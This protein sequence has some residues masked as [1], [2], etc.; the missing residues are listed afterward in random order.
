MIWFVVVP[1]VAFALAGILLKLAAP[2]LMDEPLSEEWR[3]AHVADH[4]DG[5]EV[6][7]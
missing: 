2:A 6:V 1:F 5:E 3:R 7:R 4:G